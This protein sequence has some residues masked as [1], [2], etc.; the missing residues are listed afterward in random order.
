[1]SSDWMSGWC[2]KFL[3]PLPEHSPTKCA[4]STRFLSDYQLELKFVGG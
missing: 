3:S 2:R 1:M 4:R